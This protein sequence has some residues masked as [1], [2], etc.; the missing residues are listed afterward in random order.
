MVENIL[1]TDMSKHGV[2]LKE[3]NEILALP[4]EERSWDD[5][6]KLIFLKSIVHAVDISNPTK[7]FKVAENWSKRIVQEFFH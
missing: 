4:E 6:N 1:A 2:Q 3:I 7:E 5:K